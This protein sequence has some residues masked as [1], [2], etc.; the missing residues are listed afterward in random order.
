MTEPGELIA[1]QEHCLD[2]DTCLKETMNEENL[3]SESDLRVDQEVDVD[4][5]E[6]ESSSSSSSESL[7]MSSS[8]SSESDSSTSSAHD[9]TSVNG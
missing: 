7:D 6:D 2:S 5:D 4:E 1:E 3:L 8:S 9:T